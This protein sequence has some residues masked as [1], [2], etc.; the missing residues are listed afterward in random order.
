MS[1]FDIFFNAIFNSS[2]INSS[3]CGVKGVKPKI[4]VVKSTSFSANFGAFVKSSADLAELEGWKNYVKC[5][6]YSK[7]Q[8][9][10]KSRN[11]ISL[12]IHE[13]IFAHL[14]VAFGS[15]MAFFASHFDKRFV[16]VSTW[17]DSWD[18]QKR[19]KIQTSYQQ[20]FLTHAWMNQNKT[21]K[22]I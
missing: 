3:S 17:N 20:N 6:N 1:F 9:F 4:A 11:K 2:G 10:I 7:H 12:R 21:K 15:L 22:P 8:R 14:C 13:F 19:A 18:Q 5:Q 16:L